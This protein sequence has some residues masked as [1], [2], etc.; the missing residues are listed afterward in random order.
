M[1]KNLKTVMPTELNKMAKRIE[2][3]QLKKENGATP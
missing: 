3:V 2:A 1:T